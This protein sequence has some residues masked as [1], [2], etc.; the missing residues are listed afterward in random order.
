MCSRVPFS[1]LLPTKMLVT[2]TSTPKWGV[3]WSPSYI[4]ALQFSQEV[5]L[6]MSILEIRAIHLACTSF[7]LILQ[8]STVQLITLQQCTISIGKKGSILSLGLL[9]HHHFTPVA[10]HLS[11]LQNTAADQISRNTQTLR[12]GPSMS[13]FC[14]A[15]FVSGDNQEQTYSQETRM[16]ST[17]CFTP[18]GEQILILCETHS[19]YLGYHL[20]R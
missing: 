15:S 14:R 13:L 2:D 9:H 5:H 11:G 19:L 7:L 17:R 1:R 12:N 6:Y 3:I 18:E 8:G 16:R 10:L 4:R 20:F